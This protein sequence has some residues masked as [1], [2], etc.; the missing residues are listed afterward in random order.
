[1]KVYIDIFFFVNFLMNLQVFQIMNYWR[2]KPAFTKRSIA[3]AGGAAWCHGSD[4][5]DSHQMDSL[6][7]DLCG[8]NCTFDTGCLWQNDSFRTFTMHDRILS[9]GSGCLRYVIWN[10]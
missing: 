9:D 7:G 6:D 1:M 2:K 3:G 4:A 10:P 5:W 8:R